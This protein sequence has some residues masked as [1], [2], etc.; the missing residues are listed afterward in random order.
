M[1]G[2][3]VVLYIPKRTVHSKHTVHSKRLHSKRL[4]SRRSI[5]THIHSKQHWKYDPG[6][7]NSTY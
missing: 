6:R 5:S 7:K 1:D 3:T 4:H 2:M